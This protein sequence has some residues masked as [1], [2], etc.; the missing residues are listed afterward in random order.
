M[1]HIYTNSAIYRGNTVRLDD[2]D[3]NVGQ[4][5]AELMNYDFTEL[6]KKLFELSELEQE[7]NNSTGFY[8]IE[9]TLKK[10]QDLL[11]KVEDLITNSPLSAFWQVGNECGVKLLV[12]CWSRFEDTFEKRFKGELFAVVVERKRYGRQN[13]LRR[14]IL[15]NRTVFTAS[16]RYTKH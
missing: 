1:F 13:C 10:I 6:C 12:Q 5:L 15:R 2:K 14:Y 7:L 3:Y 11:F 4:V 16:F 9:E 8:K